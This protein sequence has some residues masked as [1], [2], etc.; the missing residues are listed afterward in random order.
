M[1]SLSPVVGGIGV[2]YECSVLTLTQNTYRSPETPW[3]LLSLAATIFNN[4][5]CTGMIGYR[6]W[7]SQKL[8][9]ASELENIGARMRVSCVFL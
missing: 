4:L 2:M 6:I 7:D 1:L 9:S 3:V 5:Y 8:F